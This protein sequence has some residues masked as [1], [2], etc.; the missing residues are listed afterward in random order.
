[1]YINQIDK[2]YDNIL[3]NFFNQLNEQKLLINFKSKKKFIDHQ[4]GP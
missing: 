1:M 4:E 3:D 2:I